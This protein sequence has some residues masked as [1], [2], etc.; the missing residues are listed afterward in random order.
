[1]KKIYRNIALCGVLAMFATSCNDSFLD[2]NPTNDMNG[3]VFWKNIEH[4]EAY[5]NG[6]YNE[7]GDNG[8]YK[9]LL[10]FTGDAWSSNTKSV[11]TREAMS[12]NYASLDANQTWASTV[13]AGIEN[14]PNGN[15]NYGCWSWTLLR[16]INVFL[17]NYQRA[18]GVEAIKNRY[19][20]EA[21]FFRAWFY[22]D[23]VQNYGDV[24]LILK[25][26]DTNS[27]ELYGERTDRKVVMDQ[28][29]KDINLACDY[30]PVSWGSGKSNR[31]TKGAALA[32][33]SRICL[34]EGTYRKYHNLGDYE[35]FLQ[36]CVNAGKELMNE[37]KEEAV[38]KY[39][40]YNTGK[41]EYDYSNTDVWPDYATL[42]MSDDLESNPEVILYRKYAPDL[43]MHRQC[44]YIVNKRAGGTKDFVED[45]LYKVD[46]NTALPVGSPQL[47]GIYDDR[48]PE[49]EFANR[50]PRLSQTF[51]APC[52]VSLNATDEEKN[53]LKTAA[54]KIFQDSP[55]GSLSFPRLGDMATW[56]NP[57]GYQ[58]IKYYSRVQDKLGYGK[59]TFDYPLFRYAEVLLNQAEALAELNQINQTVLDKTI[60]VLR[61][62]VNMPHLNINPPMDPK[63]ADL[64]ISSLLVEIRRER[65]V[66]LSFEM[67]R[68][69]DLMRWAQGEKL[70][71]RV[72]GMRFEDEDY[73]NKDR[74]GKFDPTDKEEDTTKKRVIRGVY[75]PGEVV[76]NDEGKNTVTNVVRT[77]EKNGKHYI[78]V[79][80]NTN[81]AAERRSF[82]PD[83]DY[84][85]PIP[86]SALSNNPNL[87]PNPSN[88]K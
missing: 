41:P 58:L 88:N 31:I 79:Y 80:A 52:Q 50:D 64:G 86:Q 15:T 85:R 16:R 65:R 7:A 55:A 57:T 29:L 27:D 13:A 46:E 66:E 56:P 39:S 83:V 33:K 61:D 42:F 73:D 10:G 35:K 18:S 24:P 72:L 22:L 45:F 59:E 71:E 87:R 26:L 38:F 2:R 82:D 62:R 84:L 14:V 78:D 20:G 21:L 37:G 53:A 30:L 49:Q 54:K 48:T 76:L 43:L 28:V 68:Y 69:Q 70:A 60:N 5:T 51:I 11:I 8:T 77:F 44:G 1:M 12:D 47:A 6:I 4:L 81:W 40:I 32:L 74:Y 17:E 67:F 25:V 9:F 3:D 34:Y 63:Y 19:A 36:E 23:M 75:R